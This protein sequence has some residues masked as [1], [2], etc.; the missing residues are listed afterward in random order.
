MPAPKHTHPTPKIPATQEP[1]AFR[2]AQN[3]L[4]TLSNWREGSVATAV[5]MAALLPLAALWHLSSLITIAASFIGA[6]TF[7]TACHIAREHR[8]ATLALLP[9]FV[10][11]PDLATTRKRLLRARNRRALAAGLRRTAAVTQP[12]RRFDCCPLL[13]DRVAAVRLEL[14]ELANALE[15]SREPDPVSVALIHE[16][17]T[18]ACGPLYNP[19][20]SPADL[21]ATLTRARAGMHPEIRNTPASPQCGGS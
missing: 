4:A 2:A 16:L 1:S 10:Q 3:G 18:N 5:V 11:L 9:E 15:Q 7:A 20:L 8:L 13:P 14:L 21:R 17:L 12:P 19:N 6:A